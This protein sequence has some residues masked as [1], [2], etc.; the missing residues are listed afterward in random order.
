MAI[1][2]GTFETQNRILPGAYINFV[3]AASNTIPLSNR[4]YAALALE[5]P[6]GPVDEIF[7][8]TGEDLLRRS[9]TLFGREYTH[10]D[11]APLRELFRGARVAH[12]YR[13]GRDGTRAACDLAE[14]R[15]PGSLG[16]GILLVIT[17]ISEGYTVETLL[18][19][20]SVDHQA[21]A[22]ID[23]LQ[24]ND[25]VIWNREASLEGTAGLNLSGG[26]DGTPQADEYT[27][28]LAQ[29]EAYALNTLGCA[30]ADPA[31]KSLFARHVKRMR[32]ESG[33]KIQCILHRFPE[34]DYEGVISVE[35]ET[36]EGETGLV[37]WVTGMTA[38]CPINRS[39]TNR[40]YQGEFTVDTKHTKR[41]LERLL[42]GG[43]F[44][45][46]GAGS[47]EI[48]VV[49]DRN[50]LRTFEMDRSE[51]FSLNQTIRVLDQIAIDIASLFRTR[52]LG[53][54]PNDTAGRLSLWSDIVSHHRQMEQIRAIEN[55]DPADII[56]KRGESKRSVIVEDYI[57][58][59]TAMS[60]LYMT[61]VVR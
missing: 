2:G 16:N 52:Y 56:V 33:V 12:L 10:P 11:L 34:A 32:E 5:L 20:V 13:L 36:A 21:V 60:K 4:G 25:F 54:I 47:G 8:V 44:L 28:F 61:V 51:D 30:S 53:I 17:Q 31:I 58:P 27:N 26:T 39:L 29:S 42:Q 14:A 38:G 48:R 6:W 59:V 22:D 19:G 9:R 40:R 3:S 18:G 43:N 35:N 15:H 41:E 37:Y 23:A 24:D 50:T 49:E 46:H 45:F 55:F 7:T 1:G 57:M